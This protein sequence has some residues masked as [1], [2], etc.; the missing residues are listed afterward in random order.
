MIKDIKRGV[1]YNIWYYGL[2][3]GKV[4]L[5]IFII[6]LVL[7]LIYIFIDPAF[8]MMCLAFSSSAFTVG[9]LKM[10]ISELGGA[11][12]AIDS[13]FEREFEEESK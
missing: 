10:I 5:S 12:K 2:K 6:Y 9:Y 4:E 8:G 13:A 1:L 7:G 11:E 3:E